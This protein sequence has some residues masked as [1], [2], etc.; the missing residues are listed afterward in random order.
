VA[1]TSTK[2]PGVIKADI[3]RV[4]DRMQVQYRETRTGFECIHVPSIDLSSVVVPA[5]P[6]HGGAQVGVGAG[7]GTQLQQT[8]SGASGAAA[9]RPGA[10]AGVGVVKKAS[11]ISFGMKRER[12]RERGEVGYNKSV[13]EKERERERE[14]ATPGLSPTPSGS[15]SFF[16]VLPTAAAGRESVQPQP[17]QQQLGVPPNANATANGNGVG[18]A[19][20][21]SGELVSSASRTKVLPPIPRELGASSPPPPPPG[22]LV[23]VRTPSPL[24][25]SEVDR[26]VFETMGNNTL[27]V[28]FE[29][30]I[31]KVRVFVCHLGFVADVVVGAVFAVA[32]D[33]VQTREWGWMAV[34][35]AGAES[36]D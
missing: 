32:W 4:L 36:P 18:I 15:S 29:I 5:E 16:N 14:R 2:P 13:R 34:S 27:S 22:P 24:P 25:T 28:K 6:A 20:V 26:E 21:P 1:T 35:D 30:N 19:M 11:K 10:G 7:A 3:R 23:P 8:A 17:Q 31:V 9:V 12:E 33:P